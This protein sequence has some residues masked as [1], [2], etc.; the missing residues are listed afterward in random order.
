MLG[1][2]NS[3]GNPVNGSAPVGG[4]SNPQGTVGQAQQQGL[5]GQQGQQTTVSSASSTTT[6]ATS[7]GLGLGISY[8]PGSS[9]DPNG[10]QGMPA[11]SSTAQALMA[12]S[13][14]AVGRQGS[15]PG[16]NF[17]YPGGGALNAGEHLNMMST[18]QPGPSNF[19]FQSASSHAPTT[20]S[21]TT[22]AAVVAHLA[23]IPFSNDHTA[24]FTARLPSYM[25]SAG[26]SGMNLGSLSGLAF[27]GF[28]AGGA[29][30][31]PPGA[32]L[33]AKAIR[34]NLL[35]AQTVQ[36]AAAQRQREL[37][38]A[39]V[40][41]ASGVSGPNGVGS[42]QTGQ[43]VTRGTVESPAARNALK[44]DEED[45]R[46][47]ASNPGGVWGVGPGGIAGGAGGGAMASASA[48][49]NVSGHE[50]PDKE[51]R[52]IL[53]IYI[54]DYLSKRRYNAAARAFSEEAGL[55]GAVPPQDLPESF[56]YE[57]WS[58]FWEVHEARIR[59]LDQT[60][61]LNHA[62]ANSPAQSAPLRESQGFLDS[63]TG[64][65]AGGAVG[66][67]V[68]AVPASSSSQGG[69][70]VASTPENVPTPTSTVNQTS[71]LARSSA[72]FAKP[73]A[74]SS[75]DL[76]RDGTAQAASSG[77]S[78]SDGSFE[79]LTPA[80]LHASL[81]A[82]GMSGRDPSQLSNQERQMVL[83]LQR[84]GSTGG[85]ALTGS[86]LQAN[87][88]V[89]QSDG[90]VGM[91]G[92]IQA[93]LSQQGG[94]PMRMYGLQHHQQ[95]QGSTPG[96][97]VNAAMLAAAA[98]RQQQANQSAVVAA[99]SD[100]G[101]IAASNKNVMGSAS[102]SHQGL[103]NS[104][105]GQQHQLG[106]AGAAQVNGPGQQQPMPVMQQMQQQHSHQGEANAQRQKFV[107][108]QSSSGSLN[109]GGS[110]VP[111]TIG[112]QQ[113][114]Q[115][116]FHG[117]TTS[118]DNN[119]TTVD[120]SRLKQ[121]YAHQLQAQHSQHMQAL[122]QQANAIRDQASNQ[123]AAQGVAMM[124]GSA[125]AQRPP[126]A[127]SQSQSV[128]GNALMFGSNGTV[129]AQMIQ[130]QQDFQNSQ[131]GPT[132]NGM[133]GAN[134]LGAA[135]VQ[136]TLG[137]SMDPFHPYRMMLNRGQMQSS[138]TN[139]MN[140]VT[141]AGIGQ[142]QFL[143][144]DHRGL[145]GQGQY[146]DQRLLAM[147]SSVAA[148]L[149]LS[150]NAGTQAQLAIIQSQLRQQQQ[151]ILRSSQP[152]LTSAIGTPQ[153][154]ASPRYP[155]TQ[156]PNAGQPV[157][158][159]PAVGAKRK[160]K[161]GEHLSKKQ[162][163]TSTSAPATPQPTL[164]SGTIALMEAKPHI[165]ATSGY[166][167]EGVAPVH[168]AVLEAQRLAELKQEVV[169]A[170]YAE[171]NTENARGSDMSGAVNAGGEFGSVMAGI[172]GHDEI[173]NDYGMEWLANEASSNSNNAIGGPN[174][175]ATASDDSI[176]PDAPHEPLSTSMNPGTPSR[177]D[178]PSSGKV[179]GTLLADLKVHNNKVATCAFDSSSRILVSGGHD[180]K[181]VVWD[182]PEGTPGMVSKRFTLENHQQAVNA[183]R[184]SNFSGVVSRVA[185]A[186]PTEHLLSLLPLMLA[187]SSMDKS[188]RVYPLGPTE[189]VPEPIRTFLDHRAS[190][191]AV[192]FC[193]HAVIGPEGIAVNVEGLDAS[194]RINAYCGSL[195]AEGELKFWS[196]LTGKCQKSL[197]LS[198]KT[199][200][201]SNPLRFRPPNTLAPVV[202]ASAQVTIA[203]AMASSLNI[204]EFSIPGEDSNP[205]PPIP[206]SASRKASTANLAASL[207][208][209]TTEGDASIRLFST[210]HAKNIM[211]LDWSS[212][213][214]WL[215]TVSDDIICLWEV[216]QSVPD[217]CKLAAQ[218]QIS[219][220]KVSSCAFLQEQHAMSSS[221]P[222]RVASPLRP[223]LSVV[224]PRIVFGE[225][226]KLYVWD[227]SPVMASSSGSPYGKLGGSGGTSPVIAMTA[228]DK[229]LTG[230]ISGLT[231]VGAWISDDHSGSQDSS[232]EQGVGDVG[233]RDQTSKRQRRILILA[234]ASSGKEGNLKLWEVA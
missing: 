233:T 230:A 232:A 63:L 200:Y 104:I 136:G 176:M 112:G 59:E 135:L 234:S 193:P 78:G 157:A 47:G 36:Q 165:D 167:M 56:L 4:L 81:T 182:V 45:D 100:T 214:Q 178:Q 98:A 96:S 58:I 1:Q 154:P 101:I 198:S 185:S 37:S 132:G 7:V 87:G 72:S 208:S 69:Q 17:G 24:H 216:G 217:G 32:S 158:S 65:T 123:A 173:D 126:S 152:D 180:R 61:T 109:G 171:R 48:V 130:S 184:M 221:A 77:V 46:L 161:T 212:D 103:Q 215:T 204:V 54:L 119:M 107:K 164:E 142:N 3:T 153:S 170:A 191:T 129:N 120:P 150:T 27:S 133:N 102:L 140:G 116:N 95:Q 57:W 219:N 113:H 207:L 183:V 21:S 15:I 12:A 33:G 106:F 118:T 110:A 196:P 197:K 76:G 134:G 39:A 67:R 22:S 108:R 53:E 55:G 88:Q 160:R 224:P 194:L 148:N 229:D 205:P 52:R 25:S 75:P 41:R 231:C 73:A 202:A 175:W 127:Q 83:A 92:A 122:Q 186:L 141:G 117:A 199:A 223:G 29:G 86:G 40:L 131:I 91:V 71:G 147:N 227:P 151:Q 137:N 226:E 99:Q 8:G 228:Q 50:D 162:S 14:A 169:A 172:L 149:G 28:G 111:T 49:G 80:Q 13:I 144:G 93:G 145:P 168:P 9:I 211:C 222:Q 179:S 64:R 146:L 2:Q 209:S 181:V 44:G 174:D 218:Q 26:A 35:Q 19:H 210:P 20:S 5:Q 90:A 18:T 125:Y 11:P 94:A 143:G 188:V 60:T 155:N 163:V 74:G 42:Q 213:G 114:G 195:D 16:L 66:L 206:V 6:S 190:V 38:A 124:N 115:L 105:V 10:S 62:T 34:D 82:L 68:S 97:Q 23:G 159:A 201:S 156:S 203:A 31:F 189:V 121:M 192:D 84:H 225:F 166:Q 220:G 85:P 51:S 30:Q 128:N 70:F 79:D 43:D 139:N 177:V 187:T 89:P 138:L